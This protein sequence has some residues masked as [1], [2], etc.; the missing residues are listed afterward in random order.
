MSTPKFISIDLDLPEHYWQFPGLRREEI[1][2]KRY[3]GLLKELPTREH[4][5]GIELVGAGYQRQFYEP[6]SPKQK[7]EWSAT[8]NWNSVHGFLVYDMFTGGAVL[9]WSAFYRPLHSF[10]GETAKRVKAELKKLAG[11]K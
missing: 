4:L 8:A 10:K 6:N 11:V 1:L 5:N 3:I 7:L 9:M 2:P